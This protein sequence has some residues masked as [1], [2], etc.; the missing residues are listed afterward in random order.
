MKKRIEIIVLGLVL[1]LTFSCSNTSELGIP[2]TGT[3]ANSVEDKIVLL[4]KYNDTGLETVDTIEVSPE[5]TFEAYV[6]VTEPTFYRF[7]F[8]NQMVA[9]MILN[10]TEKDDIEI[11]IDIAAP[12]ERAIIT[13]SQETNHIAVFDKLIDNMREDQEL[14][15]NQGSQ[16][17]RTNNDADI[18]ELKNEYLTLLDD[19]HNDIK[20][21]ASKIKPSLAVFYGIGSLRMEEHFEFYD[22]LAVFYEQE[23]PNHP[24]SKNLISQVDKYRA[25]ELASIKIGDIAPEISLPSPDGALV[26]LSSLKGKYVLIDFW[27]AWCKPCRM[28]NP[29]VVKVYNKYKNQNFEI[30]GVSLDRTR[31]A[32]VKAI[33]SDG[34][35][36]LHVSDLK[37]FG[38]QAAQDYQI[39]AIPATYLIGPNGEVIAKNLRGA[40]LKAKLKE[41]FG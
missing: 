12:K 15:N 29:N 25:V 35:E 14:I 34:L 39:Q 13:G 40:S 31:D 4:Q 32:W 38:S 7:N 28:E 24:F 6:K 8:Y 11:S 18:E 30:L 19:F 5:G 3:I 10:G 21:Y 41:I 36:W 2:V 17:S 16:A 33:E 9:N 27:A 20:A 1:L 23:L 26:T 22:E 37:Y